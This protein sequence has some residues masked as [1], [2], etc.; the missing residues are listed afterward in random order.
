[1][2]QNNDYAGGMNGP[3]YPEY[4]QNGMIQKLMENMNSNQENE[5]ETQNNEIL[6]RIEQMEQENQRLA[7]GLD[8]DDDLPDMNNMHNNNL[9]YDD[10]K[11]IGD[12][13]DKAV[14]QYEQSKAREENELEI[15]RQRDDRRPMPRPSPEDILFAPISDQELFDYATSLPPVSKPFVP[16]STR[17]VRGHNQLEHEQFKRNTGS[18]FNNEVRKEEPTPHGLTFKDLFAQNLKNKMKP[19]SASNLSPKPQVNDLFNFQRK[20]Q[21]KNNKEEEGK[22]QNLSRAFG[23]FDANLASGKDLIT[24]FNQIRKR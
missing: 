6:K 14:K 5:L 18:N 11:I 2:P 10:Q 23:C 13:V 20:I 1:V 21:D 24:I 17:Q 15:Q 22:K 7:Q 8:S 19:P 12:A 16:P 3:L 9:D 4:D